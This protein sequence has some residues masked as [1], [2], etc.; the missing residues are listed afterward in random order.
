MLLDLGRVRC[1][2]KVAYQ[3]SK[4]F[5]PRGYFEAAD[6][7]IIA[8][9]VAERNAGA[10][11]VLV[12]AGAVLPEPSVVKLPPDMGWNLPFDYNDL[13]AVVPDLDDQA[14][15]GG[16][17]GGVIGAAQYQK[18]ADVLRAYCWEHGREKIDASAWTAERYRDP[19]IFTM[20]TALGRGGLSY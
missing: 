19:F 6:C 13:Q 20:R 4:D 15:S 1:D 18:A 16:G 10:V 7:P 9:A 11:A 2:Q 17:G 12:A 5:R 14:A 8:A 3:S